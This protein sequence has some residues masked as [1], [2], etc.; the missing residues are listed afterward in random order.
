MRDG[1]RGIDGV[2]R[3]T[4]AELVVDPALAHAAQ[5]QSRHVE[6]VQIGLGLL[7]TGAPVAQQA[8]QGLG[9]RKLRR[10][11]ESAVAIVEA[12]CELLPAALQRRGRNVQS[13]AGRRR[14]E[15]REGLRER[16]VL[17]AQL[18]LVLMV[19]LGHAGQQI[20]ERRQAVTRLLREVGAAEE[21]PLIVG[22][23]EHGERPAAGALRQQ[24]LGDLVD[25]VDVGALLAVDLDVHEQPIQ[26]R[27]GRL[28]LETLLTEHVA[29]MTRGVADAQVN[30]LVFR[31]RVLESCASPGIPI[32]GIVRVLL[33]VG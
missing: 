6:R 21:W 18:A 33:Q 29:P 17:P 20:L 26:Q 25:A 9:M 7:R 16:S 15:A 4:A 1:P 32:D 3:E 8:L 13:G 24:L 31:P 11:A 14:I 22:R 28:V 5:C 12:A 10:R 27:G 23:Q 19:I 30:R 2:A